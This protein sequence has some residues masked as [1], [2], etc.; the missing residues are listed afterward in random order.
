MASGRVRNTVVA[1]GIIVLLVGVGGVVWGQSR[2]VG[3]MAT[4]TA[5]P[6]SMTDYYAEGPQP[7]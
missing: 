3:T 2:S 4:M 5:R 7:I 6:T 1:A